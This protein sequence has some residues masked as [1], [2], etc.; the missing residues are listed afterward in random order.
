MRYN[1]LAITTA[2]FTLSLS[3]ISFAQKKVKTNPLKEEVKASVDKR[4]DA[5][6]DLSD[7]IWSFEEIAFRETQSA[8]ALADYAEELGFRVTRGVAEIPTAFVAE[9]GSGSPVIGILGEFDALPG[10]SQNK[11]PY[12]SPL[13]EGA[14][15]HGCG[16]NLFGVASLGAAASIKDLIDQGKIKGT[17]RFY[18]TPAEEKFFGKL[19]MVRAGLFKDVDVVMDWHPAAETKA[20][21]QKGLAL[22]DFQVE[23]F[24]QAAHASADPWNGRSASDALEL[25]TSGINYY[26]EH[27][28]P[29]VRIHYHIQDAGQV[30]NVVPDYS[31]IWVR[32][33]DSSR[34]GL[35]PVWKRVEEMAEG[36]AILANVDYK[37]NLISGVHEVLVNRTGSAALQKNLESLGSIS[38]TEEE[39]NFAKKIQEA[40]GKPQIG[41]VSKIEPMEETAEHSMGGS[42]DVGDVSWVV[43]TIRLSA[44]T[45]PNGTP[46]H[47]WAVVASGGMSIGHKGM[48]YAAK[49]LSMTMV[50]LFQNPEL[51]ESVK[52]EFKEKKGDYV[53][54]GFVPDG[55]PPINSNLQ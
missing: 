21:V 17:V 51:V 24:G 34:E 39:Q 54:K 12:K 19:W 44:T 22:V 46:W 25:Y 3:N 30:V 6:T 33:R 36:A 55:P 4:F 32:V 28:K 31:R 13:N 35:V 48:A 37:V 52:A 29:T 53:Y 1:Y 5:L 26:R 40:T 49:A 14:P 18:G 38:Y 43:P 47:S 15:G 23:F 41:L 45:A 42:T 9:Y 20:A 2:I 7:R 11:V 8:K 16:H 50:D 10:L 27:I